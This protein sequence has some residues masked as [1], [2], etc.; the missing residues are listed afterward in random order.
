MRKGIK[1]EKEMRREREVVV[2]NLHVSIFSVAA[3]LYIYIHFIGAV[4]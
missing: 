1:E 3:G 4:L 2:W